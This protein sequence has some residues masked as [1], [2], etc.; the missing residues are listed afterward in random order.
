M[1]PLLSVCCAFGQRQLPCAVSA[2]CWH[3][4]LPPRL[5]SSLMPVPPL[6]DPA[7]ATQQR[8]EAIGR[9]LA[10]ANREEYARLSGATHTAVS[11]RAAVPLLATVSGSAA[12][13]PPAADK[14]AAQRLE[15]SILPLR[16]RPLERRA[17]AQPEGTGRE[18][19]LQGFNWGALRGCAHGACDW[20]AGDTAVGGSQLPSAAASCH[21]RRSSLP[22]LAVILRVQ[23]DPAPPARPA[24]RQTPGSTPAAGTTTWQHTLRRLP[25]WVPRPSGCRRPQRASAM[26]ATCRVT[27]TI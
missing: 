19:L 26:R 10:A 12:A 16:L 25:A 15:N 7:I 6:Q 5:T 1:K 13:A 14:V 18:V 9:E 24:H 4:L 22:G 20:E 17:K 27:C 2:T 23:A 21:R 11:S 3:T 8:L